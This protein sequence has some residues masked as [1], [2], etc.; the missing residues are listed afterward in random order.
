MNCADPHGV[1]SFPL[2]LL[3]ML[4]FYYYY[5]YFYCSCTLKN[6]HLTVVYIFIPQSTLA[7]FYIY[8]LSI[9]SEEKLI[10]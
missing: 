4:Q 8:G 2:G 6:F 10:E 7:C 1:K 3:S 9:H 5:C